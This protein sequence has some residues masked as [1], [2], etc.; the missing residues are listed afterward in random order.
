MDQPILMADRTA[1]KV[2]GSI[3]IPLTVSNLVFNQTFAVTHTGIDGILGLDFMT[4]NDCL[5]DLRNSSMMLK[6]KRVKLSFE[7]DIGCFRSHLGQ[8]EK[9]IKLDRKM[10]RARQST[11]SSSKSVDVENE[12]QIAEEE[13][14]KQDYG[15]IPGA[16]S[17]D[18]EDSGNED[19]ARDDRPRKGK[20]KE[21]RGRVIRKRRTPAKPYAPQTN[22]PFSKSRPE[23]FPEEADSGCQKRRACIVDV[24]VQTEK[25]KTNLSIGRQKHCHDRKSK[26]KMSNHDEEVKVCFPKRKHDTWQGPYLVVKTL[27]CLTYLVKCGKRGSHQIRVDRMGK[28]CN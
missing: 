5:I 7:G 25:K 16:V 20:S 24:V 9:P 12:E 3:S 28:E 4:N 1:L 11:P 6:G 14:L 27:S 17:I 18:M 23:V 26:W 15:D 21:Q 8:T 10:D 13:W 2:E 19:V 22:S